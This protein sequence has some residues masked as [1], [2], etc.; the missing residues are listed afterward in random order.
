MEIKI[1]DF[2]DTIYS[3]DS[4]V[5]F[6]LFTLRKCPLSIL[7]IIPKL[8]LA[9]FLYF[10]KRIEKKKLKESFFSFV[11]SIPDMEQHIKNFWEEMYKKMNRWYLEKE[12]HSRDVIISASP[13][14]LLEIPARRVGVDQLIASKV[15]I[16]TG[17]FLS[18]N[19]YG[20]EKVRRLFDI[21]P[22]CTILECYS[23]S[24]SDK[25]LLDIAQKSYLVNKN[26]IRFYKGKK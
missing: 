5:D 8:I 9:F 3:G 15:D 20:Q 19:C 10:L 7:K 21:Y 12:D 16:K 1:Y 22:D 13:E 18:E 11:G 17:K 6:F 24:Y 25:P 2:D 4:S 23:D 14:F 26:E